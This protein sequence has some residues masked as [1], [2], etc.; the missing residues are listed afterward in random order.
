MIIGNG[1]GYNSGEI[2]VEIAPYNAQVAYK[3]YNKG[4]TPVEFMSIPNDV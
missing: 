4:Y 3:I 2:G 1:E